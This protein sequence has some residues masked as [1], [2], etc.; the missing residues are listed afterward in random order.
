MKLFVLD[1]NRR[2]KQEIPS[3]RQTKTLV[4]YLK[5]RAA[6]AYIP[7]TSPTSSSATRMPTIA[8]GSSGS[9]RTFAVSSCRKLRARTQPAIFFDA[10]DLRA[11]R[12]FD[13]DIP[14]CLEQT[15]FFLAM[16]SPRYNGSDYCKQKELTKFLRAK[17]RNPDG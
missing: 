16:V 1:V 7:I 5:V 2:F 4:Q 10:H 11:G 12:V 3:C 14:A 15:G 6:V 8:P 9:S 17:R 13:A